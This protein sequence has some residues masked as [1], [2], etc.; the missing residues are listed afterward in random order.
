MTP[1]SLM[2]P[3]DYCPSCEGRKA[4]SQA[5]QVGE[6]RA[7]RAE[8]QAAT[9]TEAASAAGAVPAEASFGAAET[10]RAKP[11]ATAV[12]SLLAPDLAVQA[13]LARP[14]IDASGGAGHGHGHGD[15]GAE[16]LRLRAAQ[17]Y[18]AG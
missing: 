5:V 9:E 18:G 16:A 3:V 1:I 12:Q 13:A 2:P 14:S 7:R 17:T 6:A 11:V 10:D 15:A 8:F 4:E